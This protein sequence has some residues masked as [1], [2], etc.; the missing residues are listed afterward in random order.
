MFDAVGEVISKLEDN[1]VS[2]EDP[3][4]FN[5]KVILNELL[6]NSIRHGCKSDINKAVS[7]NCLIREDGRLVLRISDEGNGY[8][9]C[10]ILKQE[11][12]DVFSLDN[13]L[14]ECGRGILI[15][16]SLCENLNF[17]SK[18]NVIEAVIKI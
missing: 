17:N 8:D 9:Y 1:L 15:V 2:L 11:L 4:L 7:I 18:G 13:N 10:N 5:I 3:E 16:R 12:C 6:V 14:K